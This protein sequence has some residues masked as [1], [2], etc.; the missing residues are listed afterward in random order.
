[1]ARSTPV[2]Q[3]DSLPKI[4]RLVDRLGAGG[5]LAEAGAAAG[6]VGRQVGYYLTAAIALGL[7]VRE[8]GDITVTPLAQ[9]LRATV[10]RSD[11]EARVWR[12]AMRESA[13]VSDIAPTL[14]ARSGPS[15]ATLTSRI[16]TMYEHRESTAGRRADTLLGWRSYVLEHESQLPLAKVTPGSSRVPYSGRP[17]L[18]ALFV[19]SFKAFGQPKAAKVA[20]SPLE[21]APLTVLAGPNGAGKSTVLQA[22]D[23]LGSL[24]RGNISEMLKAHEWDYD[25][26]PHLRSKGRTIQIGADIEL[27]DARVEWRLTLGTR[28]HPSIAAELVRAR[29]KS[30]VAWTTLLEREGRR[31]KI[32]DELAGE[33]IEMPLVTHPQSWLSTLDAK[34]D[35]KRY[36]GLLA[37]KTWAE[38][39]HAFWSLD[40]STLRSP[41]RGDAGRIG[42]RGQDLATLLF[43]MKKTRPARFGA[44][45][46]RLKRYYPRLVEIVPRSAHAG[47][48]YLDVTERWNGEK[49]T[50]NARQ[51][52]DGLLRMMVLASLPEWEER[53]SLVLLDEVENGLHPRLIGGITEL[54][55]EVAKTTQVVATTHSP[56]TLNYVPAEATR[57]VTRGRGGTVVITPLTSVKNFARLREHFDPGEL[58]YNVGE[59][60]LVKG[61]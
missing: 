23:I 9:A 18:R 40:P 22:M 26:L 7:V 57:L 59:E 49:A 50:F 2:P 4:R 12:R 46:K 25:D 5:S 8:A 45:T 41:S 3:A 31:I 21:L 32:R 48:K 38:R 56:I 28:K 16:A 10:E 44:F 11:D 39:I 43:K 60:A 33:V 47:W 30:T 14:L 37:L 61:R 19:E 27:D 36:P 1:M 35:A 13:I 51:V 6:V 24:V 42:G 15:K 54:L 20:T 34:E 58:W 17:M 52:S 53:P 55:A 29:P